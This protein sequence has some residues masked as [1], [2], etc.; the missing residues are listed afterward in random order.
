LSEREEQIEDSTGRYIEDVP[1]FLG[2]YM[3]YKDLEK[4]P[5]CR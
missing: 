5:K 2:N 3:V 1:R 4:K